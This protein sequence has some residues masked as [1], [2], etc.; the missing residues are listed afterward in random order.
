MIFYKKEH[1]CLASFV[2]VK[3]IMSFDKVAWFVCSLKLNSL[4]RNSNIEGL[5]N[6]SKDTNMRMKPHDR[7]IIC[8]HF[9]K[10]LT[11][12]VSLVCARFF[13][14]GFSSV[15]VLVLVIF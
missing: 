8:S 3:A 12:L 14:E 7:R 10:L 11:L 15:T 9:D 6:G 1:F 13:S 5:R 2:K 4:W